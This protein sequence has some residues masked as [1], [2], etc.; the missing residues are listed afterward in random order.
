LLDWAEA[1]QLRE[2]G[3]GVPI[4]L[5]GGARID[6]EAVAAAER[7]RLILT[8]LRE[9]QIDVV[10]RHARTGGSLAIK[11]EAGAER[12]GVLPFRLVPMAARIASEP[13]LNL[14]IINA[15]P[16]FREDRGRQHAPN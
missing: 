14:A 13:L 6:A 5:Y 8:V 3:I 10:A 4:L 15:H 9:S 7:F 16:T 2:D 12:L 11:V 1:I